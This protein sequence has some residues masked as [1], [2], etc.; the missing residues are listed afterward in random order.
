MSEFIQKL[1][2]N[3]I[4]VFGSNTQGRH[5]AGAAKQAMKFGAIYGQPSGLQ[6]QTYAIVTKDLTSRARYPIEKIRT[7]ILEFVE[8]AIANPQLEFLVTEIG[9][10]LAGYNPKMIGYLF[11]FL[12]VPDNVKLPDSFIR[13]DAQ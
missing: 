12:S 11:A 2:P 5:G 4:F 13:G 6:G 10:G 3:Q 8:F 7:S 1:K 9:C